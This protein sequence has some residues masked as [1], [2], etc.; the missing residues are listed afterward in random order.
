M[1]FEGF[2]GGPSRRDEP[3]YEQNS[4]RSTTIRRDAPAEASYAGGG[5]VNSNSTTRV[6]FATLPERECTSRT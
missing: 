2:L 3:S 6:M 4:E 5:G 1:N